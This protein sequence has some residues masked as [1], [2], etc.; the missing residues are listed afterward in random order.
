M[1]LLKYQDKTFATKKDL[2]RYL[3]ANKDFELFRKKS[4][5]KCS[6]AVNYAP[7]TLTNSN[8]V[9]KAVKYLYENNEKEGVLKRTLLTNTYWWMDS[10]SDVHIGRFG[11]SDKSVFTNSINQKARKIYPIDE[12]K[13]GLDGRIGSTI[14][15]YESPISWKALGVDLPGDTE[16]LF[17]DAEIHK[18]KNEKRYN[19][20]LNNEID[21]HSVGMQYINIVLAVNDADEFPEEYKA[22]ARYID[23]IGNKE[24]VEEQGFFYAILEAK[25]IEYSCVLAG[26]NEL[27]PTIQPSL[28]TDKTKPSLDTL[29]KL[30]EV[31]N[32]IA[33]INELNKLSNKL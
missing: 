16:G 19:D 8:T 22:Y 18:S 7:I 14:K 28:D 12:H 9:S 27:T 24:L 17:A 31:S 11:E 29:K 6:D 15:I 25:L 10:H 21:Q 30:E 33:L 2:H 1:S 20:Y 3:V 32:K 23:K 4:V 5:V 13:F 26:S